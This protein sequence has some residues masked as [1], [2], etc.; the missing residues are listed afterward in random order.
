MKSNRTVCDSADDFANQNRVQIFANG[1]KRK[2]ICYVLSLRTGCRKS[3]RFVI[4]PVSDS[5]KR[6]RQARQFAT[7]GFKSLDLYW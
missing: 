5:F 6:T 3:R 7:G 1:W 2:T 4:L